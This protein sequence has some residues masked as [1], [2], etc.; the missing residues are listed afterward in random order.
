[1][2]VYTS[3]LADEAKSELEALSKANLAYAE[4]FPGDLPTRQPV[5]T[6]YGGAQL[7]KAETAARLGKLALR[8]LDD[9]APDAFSFARAVA[10]EGSQDLPTSLGEQAP[11][12]ARFEADPKAFE[13]EHRSAW[14]AL[15]VYRRVRA[16]LEREAVEDLR[17][18]FED[19]F[20][21]RP[22]AEEDETAVR[23]AL[24]LS[25]AMREG[26][27]PP[28]V[29]IRIKP[30]N[31]ELKLRAV[32]TL[33][34]FITTL[35]T[36]AGRLPDGFVVTLPKIPVPEQVAT[37][38]SLF[39]RLEA[40]LKLPAK[41]LKLELMVELTAT[42]FD[43]HG[44]N[45]L[46]L[47]LKAADG[48][49]SGAHFGTYDYT[50][51]MN[52]TAA[53]QTM[54][55]PACDFAVL[56]MKNAFANT[57][58]FLSDGATN[59]MPVGPHRAAT[60][61]TLSAQ[62]SQENTESVHAAWRLAYSHIQRSLRLGIYQGWDLHPGQLPI[63]YAA[64]YAFFLSGF[65]AAADRLSNFIDKAAQATLVGN[66]FDDA[67]TGQG[68]LNYFLRGVACGAVSLEE[69]GTT[70]LTEEE[71]QLRSF[72]KILDARTARG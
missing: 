37:L 51:S 38:V 26:L 44:M 67:A 59:V 56:L 9:F 42:F 72:A 64:L 40:R 34:L 58:V 68:L 71:M 6:V 10:M 8:A 31:E 7:Y 36:D 14:L 47:L 13:H 65:S 4:A 15:T 39:E 30:F 24:E 18:D 2:T 29:G 66:V 50:A 25:R 12:V 23:T 43:R 33:D 22:D 69:L 45:N 46:P 17:I 27:A 41:S 1:M 20:G 70:G 11:L 16:K 35:V 52:I 54:D 28:F 19:G 55:H 32:R 61:E 63:R 62:Q 57:G 5:H 49:C 53:F 48:R 21:N 60:G 3:T